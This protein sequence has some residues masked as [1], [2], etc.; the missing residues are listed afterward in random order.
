VA[1]GSYLF[2]FA[3]LLLLE[4]AAIPQPVERALAYAGPSAMAALA[5]SALLGDRD[6]TGSPTTSLV[7]AVALAVAAV[8]AM[9]RRPFLLAVGAALVVF[10]WLDAALL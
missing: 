8:L 5:A 2:R 7:T 9:S 10:A 3:P 4:R 1:L 6:L